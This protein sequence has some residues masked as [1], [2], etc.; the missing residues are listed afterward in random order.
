MFQLG[1]MGQGVLNQV[2]DMLIGESVEQ[3]GAGPAAHDQPFAA[4]ESKALVNGRE[5]FTERFDKFRDTAF[6]GNEL[7]EQ[8][9]PWSIPQGAK[10]PARP[11]ESGWVGGGPVLMAMT[12]GVTC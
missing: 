2:D 7:L 5:F 8:P 1:R 4:Q 9:Q 3:V 11:L 10:E 6:A 12:R